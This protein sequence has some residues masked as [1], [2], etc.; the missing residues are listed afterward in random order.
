MWLQKSTTDAI[1]TLQQILEKRRE[2]NLPT[3]ILFVDYEKAY[4]NLTP[5]KA[6]ADS[7]GGRHTNATFKSNTES[8]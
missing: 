1:C 6:V 4:D 2:F 5:T 3:F 7:K 8:Q